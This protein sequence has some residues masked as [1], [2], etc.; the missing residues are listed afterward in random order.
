MMYDCFFFDI[1]MLKCVTDMRNVMRMESGTS[2]TS[3]MELVQEEASS[4][5]STWG[6]HASWAHRRTSFEKG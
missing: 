3:T 6:I 2:C 4:T 5:R 1:P